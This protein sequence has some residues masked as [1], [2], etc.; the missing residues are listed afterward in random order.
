MDAKDQSAVL[1]ALQSLS[2][3]I[4]LLK[5]NLTHFGLPITLA[6]S[7]RVINCEGY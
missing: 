3:S 7:L 4:S 5:S 6:V 1:T 2:N